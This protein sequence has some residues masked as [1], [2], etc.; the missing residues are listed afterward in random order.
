MPD[1]EDAKNIFLKFCDWAINITAALSDEQMQSM[2]D[3]EQGG[4]NEVLADAYQIT[5][6]EKVSY[7]SKKIFA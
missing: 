6:E 3:T 2:L 7:R 1:N 5:G 4:M